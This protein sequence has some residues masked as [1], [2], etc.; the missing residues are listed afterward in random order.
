MKRLL[1]LLLVVISF[2]A[3]LADK[4]I[5]AADRSIGVGQ[6][7]YFS[8]AMLERM[9]SSIDKRLENAADSLDFKG[10]IQAT[11][12]VQGIRSKGSVN[13]F[14]MNYY[15]RRVQTGTRSRGTREQYSPEG[16][17]IPSSRHSDQETPHARSE[18]Q[19]LTTTTQDPWTPDDLAIPEIPGLDGEFANQAVGDTAANGRL[20][21]IQLL[22]ERVSLAF[23]QINLRHLLS[24]SF[25]DQHEKERVTVGFDISVQPRHQHHNSLAEVIVRLPK[26]LNDAGTVDHQTTLI[27]LFPREET[28][29]TVSITQDLSNTGFAA[30]LG[31]ISLGFQGEDQEKIGYVVQDVDTVAITNSTENHLEFGWQFRP[32]L[33]REYVRPGV[34]RVYAVLGIP[35]AWLDKH[36]VSQ[37]PLEVRTSWL[38][39]QCDSVAIEHS[40]DNT[41]WERRTLFL[42]DTESVMPDLLPFGYDGFNSRILDVGGQDEE[43]REQFL[44][45]L[46]GTNFS[47]DMDLR[48]G[49][50]KIEKMRLGVGRVEN[51]GLNTSRGVRATR[52]VRTGPSNKADDFFRRLK[53]NSGDRSPS[54][55]G[56]SPELLIQTLTFP[57][58][59]GLMRQGS[60][61]TVGNEWGRRSW[62]LSDI[63]GQDQLK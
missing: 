34:R 41:N 37:L 42:A 40:H 26:H 1:T 51:F 50:E 53:K 18:S 12:R 4:E 17:R 19:D 30:A 60:I 52:G 36:T 48:I 44:V 54:V 35:K 3:A 2:L 13:V 63:F 22:R 31:P 6:P 5:D 27:H 20:S 29:N 45:V 8:Q 33:G 11:G 32:V 57:V 46:Y 23:E 9:L 10:D 43:G 56:A 47:D 55:P 14:N 61:V 38:R 7:R 21:S 24:L 28:Y 25:W 49:N 62:R 58:R 15:P 59:K 16:N 39:T